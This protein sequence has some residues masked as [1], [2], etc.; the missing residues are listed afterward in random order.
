[1]EE[2]RRGVGS[3][4]EDIIRKEWWDEQCG[5]GMRRL[6]EDSPA[7]TTW[8]AEFL[9]GKELSKEVKVI[10]KWMANEAVPWTLQKTWLQ[11]IA[12]IFPSRKCSWTVS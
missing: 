9:F 11:T 5:E 1:M 12:R 4:N 10:G 2:V 8:E 7:A 6:H 3:H